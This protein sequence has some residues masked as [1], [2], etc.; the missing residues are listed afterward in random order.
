MEASDRRKFPRLNMG[1]DARVLEINGSELGCVSQVSGAGMLIECSSEAI[2]ERLVSEGELRVV[3]VE[4]R[5]Q[6]MNTFDVAVRYR[7]DR[8][9]GFEFIDSL[10]PEI[11]ETLS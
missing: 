8:F 9:V 10:K 3:I 7:E 2:A 11:S 1:E 6:A 5:N 4:P